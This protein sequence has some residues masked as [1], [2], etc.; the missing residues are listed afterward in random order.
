MSR[1]YLVS[2]SSKNRKYET[3]EV[4]Q[5][6][7]DGKRLKKYSSIKEA[8]LKSGCEKTNI[9]RVCNGQRKTCGG[10]IW[11]YYTPPNIKEKD[12][13]LEWR[14]VQRFP[15]YEVSIDGQVYSHRAKRVL[16][17]INQSSGYLHTSV[18][19]GKHVPIHQ[20]VAEAFIPNPDN[21]PFLN[22]INGNPKD[23]R[24]ENL[25][26]TDN[27]GNIQHAYDNGL[28]SN[29]RRIV[30][31]DISGDIIQEYMNI[32]SA[33]RDMGIDSR[34]IKKACDKRAQ[35]LYKEYFRY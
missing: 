23:N 13:S 31:C 2:E 26:W 15:R 8:A 1:A 33:A 35:I 19:A 34:G 28:Y 27:S 4:I 6:S 20:L 12:N 29:I 25:E 5:L 16:K 11:K 21:L 30:K 9:S 18:G 24:A 32:S 14:V 10:Y 17:Q 7:T 3:I 22:H